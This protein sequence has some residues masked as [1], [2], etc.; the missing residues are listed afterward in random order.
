MDQLK[1]VK[2]SSMDGHLSGDISHKSA[3]GF[4][5]FK[6]LIFGSYLMSRF[7]IRFMAKTKK[8]GVTISIHTRLKRIES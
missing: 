5:G 4:L 6:F 8:I 3:F 1:I 2:Q 7:F